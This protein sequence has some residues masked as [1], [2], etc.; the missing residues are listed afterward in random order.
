MEGRSH[1]QR[2]DSGAVNRLFID[3]VAYGLSGLLL[4]DDAMKATGRQ[5]VE[6][7]LER[8]REDGVFLE[9][10]GADSSYQA[11]SIQFLQTFALY[12][13]DKRYDEALARAAKWM[14]GRILPSGQVDATG[15]TRTGL[16]QERLYGRPK[17]VNYN[18]VF[19]GLGLYG[20]RTGDGSA[21]EAAERTYK[22]YVEI[23]RARPAKK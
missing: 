1:L 8:Q 20:L 15:N 14:L 11:V 21:V 19:L 5:A 16:G 3:A 23:R 18:H 6:F 10:K 2:A 12:F 7:G 9:H 4:D 13:P 22:F 17:G